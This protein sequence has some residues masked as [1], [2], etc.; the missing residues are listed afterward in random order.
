MIKFFFQSIILYVVLLLISKLFAIL[1]TFF[2][3]SLGISI[4]NFSLLLSFFLLSVMILFLK[5][6]LV[7][8]KD[9]ISN[10]MSILVL[11]MILITNVVN[12]FY[13]S[14]FYFNY[15][16]VT[17]LVLIWIAI[18][19]YERKLRNKFYSF[20]L[21]QMLL[22]MVLL[23]QF[24]IIIYLPHLSIL[25]L[26]DRIENDLNAYHKDTLSSISSQTETFIVELY[27]N[28]VD[29]FKS[30]LCSL[31]KSCEIFLTERE[32]YFNDNFETTLTIDYTSLD[33]FF[34]ISYFTS[35]FFSFIVNLF[36]SLIFV[37]YSY[38]HFKYFTKP[39]VWI[40]DPFNVLR[41]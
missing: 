29:L 23:I 25:N 8:L 32:K 21:T 15:F 30:E 36:V 4:L 2:L 9:L 34:Y 11:V 35:M 27:S 1:E 31:N 19:F 20:G 5:F 40:I 12:L 37:M 13:S 22:F 39:V 3:N 6:L 28:E 14:L 24:L 33:S 7:E 38:K 16:F 18:Y 41:F 26:N 17:L 10:K